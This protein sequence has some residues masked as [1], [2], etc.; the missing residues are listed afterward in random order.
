TGT[1]SITGRWL[2]P[3]ESGEL[4]RTM[5]AP[6]VPLPAPL[7]ALLRQ[8]KL[9]KHYAADGEVAALVDMART[10]LQDAR[11]AQLNIGSRYDL[12]YYSVLAASLAALRWYNCRTDSAFL[13]FQSLQFTAGLA[14]PEW[15]T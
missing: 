9:K 14:K 7:Q 11:N 3:H 4:E 8:R 2:M 5:D 15:R 12:A 13:I 6:A 10:R 1:G